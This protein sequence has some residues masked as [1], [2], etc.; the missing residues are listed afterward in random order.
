MRY[1][2]II[3]GAGSS[4]STLAARLTENPDT[5]VL[6]LEAGPDYRSAD[7]PAAMQ[8]PNPFHIILDPAYAQYRYDD[9]MARRNPSQEP[10]QYWRGRG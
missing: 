9:V 5:T 8:I 2:Y 6:L 4:G 7:T 10:R 3:V 1:D